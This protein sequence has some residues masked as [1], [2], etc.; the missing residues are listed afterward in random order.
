VSGSWAGDAKQRQQAGGVAGVAAQR[1]G[2][3]AVA[4]GPEDADGQGLRRLAMARGVVPVR[5]WEASSAKVV[6]RMWCSASN[7]CADCAYG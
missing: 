7:R 6:S 2:D 4:A 5:V 1:G 3:V